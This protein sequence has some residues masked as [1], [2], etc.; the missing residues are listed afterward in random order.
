MNRRDFVTLLSG[1]PVAAAFEIASAQTTAEMSVEDFFRKPAFGGASLSPD[2]LNL[3][4]IV[5]ANG[6]FNL[7]IYNLEARKALRITDLSSVD[8]ASVQW[9]NNQRVIFTTGDQQ[10]K[11]FRGDGGLF[12]ADVDGKNATVLVK[13]FLTGSSVSYVPRI[14]SVLRRLRGNKDDVLVA[15][16]DRTADSQDLYRMNVTTG[17]KSLVNASSPGNVVAWAV[18]GNDA[19]RAAY[20]IDA[21]KR[22]Y[23]FAYQAEPNSRDWKTIAEWDEQLKDVMIPLAFDPADPKLIYV[24]SNSGRD[25]MALFLFDTSA[26][27]L[28]EM[29]YG[30]DRYDVF[31][32]FLLGSALGEGG[33]LIFGGNEDAPGKLI[34]LRYAADKLKHIWF[35]EAAARTHAAIEASFPGATNTFNVNTKKALVY[36]RSD[37][38]AGE[39]FLFDRDKRSLE[40]TGVR[41]RPQIDPKAMRSKL[42][43]SWLAR[44]GLRIDGYLTLPAQWKKGNPVPMV[45]HPHGGPWAK[46]N[47]DFNPEVQFMANRGFAVLQANFRGSTGYGAKHLRLSYK[48][49]GGTMIDDM[50]DGVEWAVKEGYADPARMG[51]YGAS[52]GGYSTLMA[53]VRRPD[54][55]KWGVNYV[56]VT[57]MVVH[58]DTQPAQLRGDFSELAKRING[59]QKAD[60]AL[61]AD[62]SPTRQVAKIAAPVFHAYGGED[63][64]VDYANGRAIR[65]AFDKAGKP[66]EWMFVADEAHGYRQDANVFEFYKRFDAFIKM[67]TPKAS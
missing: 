53:M 44:D 36:T 29:I 66:Y 2:Q 15:A 58:Q 62:Q 47:W 4:A 54:L 27:K 13:P 26:G 22:R 12:A 10:G 19:P 21:A 37:T 67:H 35:D 42:P 11:E 48:Q 20:C 33:A 17:R 23:W 25:T 61:F 18:D 59:D 56:G 6:R 50:I 30:D 3:A 60:A 8:V 41:T 63:R 34:G 40:E 7:V 38:N 24:A 31:S 39:Y 57:D 46:D 55:F 51:V 9:A 45:L 14:T 65:S 28:L 1:V 32:F 5:P 43:V 52:Y 16:N 64:N 49:W